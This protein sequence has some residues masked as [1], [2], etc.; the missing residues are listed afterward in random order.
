MS[1]IKSEHQWISVKKELVELAKEILEKESTKDEAEAASDSR[2]I[3]YV[4]ETLGW[5]PLNL[6]NARLLDEKMRQKYPLICKLTDMH[7]SKSVYT[8]NYNPIL[9]KETII[10]QRLQTDLHGIFVTV[11]SKHQII[12]CIEDYIEHEEEKF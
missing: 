5:S 4:I 3:S 9:D 12:K 2:Q 6:E 10:I 1:N 11:L 7:T 8:S